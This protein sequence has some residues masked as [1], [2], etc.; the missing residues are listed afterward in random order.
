MLCIMWRSCKWDIN[1]LTVMLKNV[2]IAVILKPGD[3]LPTEVSLME[4]YDLSR[5]TVRQAIID[6]VHK[7]Y[8]VREKAKGTFVKDISATLSYKDKVKGF[9]QF[10]R[11][12]GKEGTDKQGVR[13]EGSS[14]AFLYL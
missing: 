11:L 12:D 7:G 1:S 10:S 9:G 8:V 4:K 13:A 2:K 5:S 14:S 3:M 6:L